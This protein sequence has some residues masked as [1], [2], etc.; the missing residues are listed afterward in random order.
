MRILLATNNQHKKSEIEPLLP[1][2]SL[3]LPADLGLKFHYEEPYS[4]F[5]ENSLGK[6]LALTGACAF[7]VLA[8]DSGLCVEALGNAPGVHSA[9]FGSKPDGN[10]LSGEDKISL[11][12]AALEG[13]K[14]RNA[15]FVCSLVIMWEP[16]RFYHIQDIVRGVITA[17]PRGTGGFGY[18]PV[19]FIPETGKTM[20][21]LTR[22]EKNLISHRGRAVNKLSLLIADEK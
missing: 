19:F 16:F 17:E 9:R 7:P 21:E 10:I 11:L 8:D 6:A 13:E 1:G 15:F 5:R 2:H 4:T 12:L 22:E 14:N 18:D 20:A 3:L